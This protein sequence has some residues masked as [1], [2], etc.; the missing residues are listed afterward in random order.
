MLFTVARSSQRSRLSHVWSLR[1]APGPPLL[2]LLQKR[3][4]DEF[5]DD[6]TAA[7]VGANTALRASNSRPRALLYLYANAP[8][9]RSAVP[10]LRLIVTE[11]RVTATKR[12]TFGTCREQVENNNSPLL[13]RYMWSV[14]YQNF[15]LYRERFFYKVIFWQWNIIKYR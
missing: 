3:L 7:A 6:P 15:Q 10:T 14:V 8:S 12:V 2:R 13:S 11:T 5:A 1:T 4:G 9:F